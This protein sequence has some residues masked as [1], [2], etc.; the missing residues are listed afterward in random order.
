[1]IELRVADLKQVAY[2]PRIVFYEYVMPVEKK[3]TY[4]ME[5]GKK[6]EEVIARLEKRRSFRRYGLADGAR[7]FGLRLY[8]EDLGLSGMIDLLIETEAELFPVDF[9]NTA[10]GPQRNHYLQL[11][12]YAL[13]AE[14]QLKKPA[15]VGYIYATLRD[16]VWRV[17]LPGA[18]KAE[19]AQRLA[20]IRD[21]ILSESLPPAT[22]VRRRC[23]E[24]EFLNYC[25]DVL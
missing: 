4:K 11:A 6:T 17:E 13:L 25:G 10:G 23:E 5:E 3:A 7:H 8:S 22:P 20:A 19:A 15:N 18:L 14:D 24:C 2:C 12:G 16:R 21:M 1:M 9:K